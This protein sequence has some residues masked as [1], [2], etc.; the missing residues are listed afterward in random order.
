LFDRRPASHLRRVIAIAQRGR[1]TFQQEDAAAHHHGSALVDIEPHRDLSGSAD[2]SHRLD[3]LLRPLP[4]L[5]RLRVEAG[6]AERSVLAVACPGHQQPDVRLG[7]DEGAATL[8]ARQQSFR[9]Q[10][11][12]S[13]PHGRTAGPV[14]GGQVVL[15]RNAGSRRTLTVED[16]GP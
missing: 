14:P 5:E 16:L 10:Q 2:G 12:Q 4:L 8:L 13:T 7:A 15:R 3:A 6:Q 9:L 11:G 1:R